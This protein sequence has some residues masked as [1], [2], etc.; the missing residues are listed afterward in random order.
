MTQLTGRVFFVLVFMATNG[1]A[2]ENWHQWRGPAN[3]GYSATATPPLNWSEKKNIRWKAEIEGHC[4]SSPIV[5]GDRVFLLAA[6][7]TGAIDPTLP[8]P[9]DQPE[10]VFGIKFPNTRYEMVVLCIDR[11][12]GKTIWREVARSLV[13]HEG[14]HR[15]ASFASASPFCD[16]ERLYCWFG[17]AGMFAYSLDGEKLW[18]RDLGKARIGASLG[19]GSSPVVHG[20][21]VVLVRDFDRGQ[22]T[23]EVLDAVDGKTLWEKDRD[24]KNAWATPAI[25]T[26]EGV[27][28]V[29]TTASNQVRSYDLGTGELI[30]WATGL[31]GN[32]TPGPIVD[33]DVVYCMSGYQGHSLLAIPITGKGDMTSSILWSADR[34]TP[35]V[36]SGLLHDGRLYYI[37]S[38]QNILTSRLAS[39]GS[40]VIS[41]TRIP[42]LGDIYASP[43]A[44][45]GKL[46][47][48]GRK[49]TTVVLA[50]GDELK[51]LATNQLDDNFHAS[52]ALWG[53]QMFLR[54]MRYLYC[55]EEGADSGGRIIASKRHQSMTPQ[56]R[57]E[58][59]R[60]LL[61]TIAE[62]ELPKDYPGGKGHQPF[63]DRWFASAPPEKARRV[64]MLWK[65]QRRLFPNMKN[66]GESFIKIL[67]HVRTGQ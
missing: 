28:Q 26:R 10:R 14:H 33:G 36:P 39:D 46:Y 30:W 3:N 58:A 61:S 18:E 7:N 37:Q 29:I 38:N 57:D 62:R 24:E 5:W 32:C 53:N 25:V 59:S 23:I 16:G 6:R 34:G 66:R 67:D 64:G 27:T 49:G 55:L 13:P 51:V 42:E 2:A 52:P 63:V 35:Y 60:K 47:F 54:G 50:P 48:V 31:T 12:T 44:A 8:S 21:K 40:E 22:S 15:D 43:V 9:E 19:E 1:L 65:E 17:S 45:N 20:G 4:V 56:N 41:R 11:K